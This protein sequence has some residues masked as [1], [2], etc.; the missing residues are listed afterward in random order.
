L[1]ARTVIVFAL[2]VGVST[3]CSGGGEPVPAASRPAPSPTSAAASPPVMELRYSFDGPLDGPVPDEAGRLP[4]HA[5]TDKGGALRSVPHGPGRAV[6]FPDR[7][8][9][10]EPK[11]CPRAI[12]ESDP[13]AQLNPDTR[14]LRYGAAVR[15]SAEQ[16]VNGANVLQK[17]FSASGS[18][19]KL[20]V[21]HG[22]PSCV[23]VDARQKDIHRAE[24]PAPIVDGLWHELACERV[25]AALSLSVD[26]KPAAQVALPADLSIVND[27]PLRIG[28]KGISANNDQFSG[29][30]DDVYLVIA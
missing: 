26:G 28:G 5:V 14:R 6:G 3:G 30:I 15:I 22:R 16:V 8:L 4:L 11:T 7:C 20:Q 21:D 19:F 23:V 2:L 13:A 18:Q 9:A 12:L 24:S 1:F 17:G 25:G 10:A 29:E 27:E